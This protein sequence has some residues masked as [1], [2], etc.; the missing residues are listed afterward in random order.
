MSTL[1]AKVAKKIDNVLAKYGR[2]GLITSQ[3]QKETSGYTND[4]KRVTSGPGAAQSFTVKMSP[5][6]QEFAAG[7]N[8]QSQPTGKSY[9]IISG[10]GLTFTPQVGDNITLDSKVWK[11]TSVDAYSAGTQIA[12]YQLGVEGG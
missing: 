12:A 6:Q 5:I 2:P 11:V 3:P 10:T 8:G 9:T 1:D 4:N 7:P